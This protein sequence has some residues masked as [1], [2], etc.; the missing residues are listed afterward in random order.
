MSTL[1]VFFLVKSTRKHRALDSLVQQG[2]SFPSV[3]PT[4]SAGSS[5]GNLVFMWRVPQQIGPL[6]GLE[7]SQSTIEAVK[8]VLPVYHTRAMRSDMFK[9]FG[10][11]SQLVK[12]AV[13]RFFY[14][15]LTG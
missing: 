5:I 11:V 3:I 9:K 7:T 10:R 15:S 14:K 13:L 2:L 8:E 12:P 4:Y 1:P 6:Q